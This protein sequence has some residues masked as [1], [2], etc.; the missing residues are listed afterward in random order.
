MTLNKGLCRAVGVLLLIAA[1][2]DAVT[3]NWNRPSANVC[4]SITNV[5]GTAPAGC[6][7]VNYTLAM[8]LALVGVGLLVL[9][10]F[11]KSDR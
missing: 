5:T 6:G 4:S 3:L 1:F 7:P 11:F 10:S 2:A 8:V 9:P